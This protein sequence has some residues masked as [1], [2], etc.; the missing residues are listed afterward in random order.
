MH[1]ALI[2]FGALL[3]FAAIGSASSK[4]LK[5]PDVMTAM[6]AVG[7]KPNQIPLLAYIE[8]AGG[9]GIIVGIWNQQLGLLATIGLTLYFGIALI[10]H[11][12]RRHKVSDYGAAM[13]IFIITLVTLYLQQRR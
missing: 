7:V 13:G 3:A 11:F 6:A 2:I 5:V 1:I 9:L 4:L 8:I 10:V 12:S